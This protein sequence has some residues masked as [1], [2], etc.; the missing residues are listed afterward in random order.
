MI[1]RGDDPDVSSIEDLEETLLQADV[2][3]RLVAECMKSLEAKSTEPRSARLR[4]LL[5][6][7]LG[8]EATIDWRGDEKPLTIL[9]VGVNGSGKTTTAAKLAYRAA[10]AGVRP[11]LGAADTFRA[12]GS[13]Q[14]RL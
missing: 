10:Q 6:N 3:A 8:P 5:M 7:S 9:I 2:P 1:G 14:L 11:L 4:S 12:A 13:E